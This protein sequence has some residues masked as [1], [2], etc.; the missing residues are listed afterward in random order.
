MNAMVA[1]AVLVA[2]APLESGGDAAIRRGLLASAWPWLVGGAAAL[3]GYGFAVNANRTIDF[4]RLMGGYIAL[5][6]V[7]SQ[8]VAWLAFGER[9]TPTLLVGGALVVAGGLVIQSGAP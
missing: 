5:F 2:A 3:V 1:F 4:T 9:P 7:V 8:V 6:F